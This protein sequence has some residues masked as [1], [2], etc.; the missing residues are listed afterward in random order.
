MD[1]LPE[2]PAAA[3]LAPEIRSRARE[4]ESVRRLPADLAHQLAEAGVFRMAIAKGYGGGERQP[5]DLIRVIEEVSRADGSVGWCV[6]IGSVTGALSGFLPAA[7]AR[8]IH[9]VTQHRMVNRSVFE[10][11]RQTVFRDA[12][13]F[14]FRLARSQPKEI[15]DG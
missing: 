14:V 4:F 10:T 7:T 13:G 8:D 9:V 11:H 15:G 5:A 6:T 2:L 1:A 3:A 12:G